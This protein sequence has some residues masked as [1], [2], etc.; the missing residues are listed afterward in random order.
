VNGSIIVVAVAG[1]TDWLVSLIVVGEVEGRR[2][3]VNHK[4][5]ARA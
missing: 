5:C 4:Y 3:Y 1:T 2:V